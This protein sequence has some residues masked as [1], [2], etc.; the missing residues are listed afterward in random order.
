LLLIFVSCGKCPV[1]LGLS[2]RHS[3]FG[4]DDKG[5]KKIP[6]EDT[7]PTIV[8]MHY[9]FKPVDVDESIG[10]GLLL[11]IHLSMKF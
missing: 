1:D 11:V 8:S 4:G 3:G 10:G 2:L 7:A 9:R 5:E 6:D